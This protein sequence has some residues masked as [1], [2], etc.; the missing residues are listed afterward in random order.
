MLKIN[1]STPKIIDV[2]DKTCKKVV[3][4]AG[5]T[6]KEVWSKTSNEAKYDVAKYDI[7]K[8]N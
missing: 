2:N 4:L 6:Q 7:D 8:F 1:N 3:L 5:S